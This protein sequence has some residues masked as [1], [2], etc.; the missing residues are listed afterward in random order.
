[1]PRPSNSERV[2][3]PA[4][5]VIAEI[6]ANVGAIHIFA[7]RLEEYCMPLSKKDLEVTLEDLSKISTDVNTILGALGR[8]KACLYE[9]T[10]ILRTKP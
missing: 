1:M 6:Q 3:R 8:S 5:M 10:K 7:G 2:L 9:L 4:W